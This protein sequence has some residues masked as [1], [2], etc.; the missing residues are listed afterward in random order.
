MLKIDY[1]PRKY[2]LKLLCLATLLFNG[3]LALKSNPSKSVYTEIQKRNTDKTIATYDIP[4]TDANKSTN[5]VPSVL[6]KKYLSD[7]HSIDTETEVSI[8]P[9]SI[10][11]KVNKLEARLKAEEEERQKTNIHVQSLIKKISDLQKSKDDAEK[12]FANTRK[13]LEA[14]NK[15][16]LKRIKKISTK[17]KGATDR[18]TQGS[19]YLSDGSTIGLGIIDGGEE[20]IA[21]EKIKRLENRLNAE[22]DK[23][24]ALNEELSTLQAAKESAESNFAN[25]RK[26]LEEK[27]NEL[28][29]KINELDS[30]LEE[31]ESRAIAAEQELVPIKKELLKTQISETKAQQ[32]LYKLKIQNLK[33][34]EE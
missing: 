33:E 4:I 27:N 16:I 20:I 2:I 31:L 28:L 6:E 23:T 17:S 15:I 29:E 5:K 13:K 24:K 32:Q 11:E 21:L 30:K 22:K 25:T 12:Y 26:E 8:E 10:Q 19:G 1:S 14:E 9:L 3:C 18:E 34:D 7:E